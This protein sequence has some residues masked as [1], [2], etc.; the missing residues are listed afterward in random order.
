MVFTHLVR[1]ALWY[2][3]DHNDNSKP[4]SSSGSTDMLHLT[5]PR[6]KGYSLRML[7]PPFLVGTTNPETVKPF[8][9]EIKLG[10]CRR[11]HAEALRNRDVRVAVR[12]CLCKPHRENA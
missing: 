9:K 10:L 2:I 5:K 1:L 12:S 3:I 11:T 8:G 4:L 7:T 6:G